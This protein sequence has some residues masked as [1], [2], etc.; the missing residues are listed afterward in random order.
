MHALPRALLSS[1]LI[2]PPG[3]LATFLVTLRATIPRPRCPV[4]KKTRG[5]PSQAA[6]IIDGD[7]SCIPPTSSLSLQPHPP[8]YPPWI[9]MN[10]KDNFATG[11]PPPS[12]SPL[13]FH[14]SSTSVGSHFG[15]P[16]FVSTPPLLYSRPPSPTPLP[17]KIPFETDAVMQI[18]ARIF[19]NVIL[20]RSETGP[21]P[22]GWSRGG[23]WLVAPASVT[24]PRE[25]V[26]RICINSH[27]SAAEQHR[28]SIIT[29]LFTDGCEN[30][31]CE[32]Y[33]ECESD[34]GGEAK[35]VC[36]SK[37]ETLVSLWKATLML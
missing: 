18:R 13:P 5:K 17:L 33:S 29:D 9:S 6:S 22:P 30:K 10:S 11:K 2:L 15:A 21:L 23:G 1:R 25:C 32:F 3:P 31:K 14:P 26:S 35:C 28:F 12:F 36:P 8:S 24:K 34:N 7:P 27:R 37:C 4:F 20:R 19:I 16:P